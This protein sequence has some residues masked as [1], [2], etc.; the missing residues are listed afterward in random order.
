MALDEHVVVNR[1]PDGVS[2]LVDDTAFSRVIENLL[3]NAAKFSDAGTTITLDAT[4]GDEMVDVT[5]T[6]QGEG[7]AAVDVDRVFDRFY[8]VGGPDNR[9][10]GTGIGLAIV[11]DFTEAQGGTVSVRST[12]GSG[13]TFTLSLRRAPAVS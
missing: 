10:P 1:I 6:D 7:I 5:V 3:S 8:R 2:V 4:V 13:T 9:K 11:K 12:L